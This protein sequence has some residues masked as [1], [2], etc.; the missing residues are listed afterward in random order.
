VGKELVVMAEGEV[1]GTHFGRTEADA[2]EIDGI[3]YF[4]TRKPVPPGE[5]VPVRIT[6]VKGAYDLKGQ[7]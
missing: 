4:S 2:P 6:G 1:R 5:L 7:A 3:V